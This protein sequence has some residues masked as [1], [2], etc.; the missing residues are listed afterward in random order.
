[1]RPF[2]V[3]IHARDDVQD[4]RVDPLEHVTGER[5]LGNHVGLE[6]DTRQRRGDLTVPPRYTTAGAPACPRQAWCASPL[7]GGDLSHI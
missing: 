5:L 4:T 7:P 6:L 3:V 1:M 2:I